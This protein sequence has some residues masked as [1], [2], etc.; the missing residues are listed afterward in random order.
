[1]RNKVAAVVVAASVVGVAA[2][3][4]AATGRGG[5]ELD[6][7]T[8]RWTNESVSTSSTQWANIGRLSSGT[9][10]Q[11]DPSTT[12]TVSLELAEGSSPVDV[13]VVMDDPLA[14]CVDCTG[15]EGLMRPRAVR[16]EA[17][18]TFN[19]VARKAI[20][21]HGTDFYVQWRLAEGSPPNASATLESG[22]LNLLWKE[23]EGLCM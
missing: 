6:R 3:A 19:F 12:A 10:C 2:V 18:S 11:E 8:F 21:G 13:R 4:F 23:L 7:Q 17:T 14:E 16:Y 22:T 5:G 9:G 20:G 15:P 1:M